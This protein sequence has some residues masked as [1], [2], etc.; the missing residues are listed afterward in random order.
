[1]DY[2]D[3]IFAH[4]PDST[5]PSAPITRIFA[6]SFGLNSSFLSSSDGGD[7]PRVQLRH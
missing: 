5:G 4:R 1:M 2:V 3:V 7:C 6:S